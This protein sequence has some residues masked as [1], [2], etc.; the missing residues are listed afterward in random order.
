MRTDGIYRVS[1]NLSQ[2]Q[3]LRFQ[4]D[5][6][7]YSGMESE[8]DVNVLTGLLKLFFRELKE[9]MVPFYLYDRLM[10]ANSKSAIYQSNP[11]IFVPCKSRFFHPKKFRKKKP[12]RRN[13]KNSLH[14]CH[15][16]TPKLYDISCITYIGNVCQS[17]K[18]LV[19]FYLIDFDSRIADFGDQNRMHL[20]NLAI[21]FGPTLMWPEVPSV[22]LATDMVILMKILYKN[23]CF[24]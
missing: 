11:F 16:Q 21:V 23:S 3:K 22:N 6:D 10:K 24:I 15:G 8:E 14:N 5:Q 1:G 13:S 18:A 2:V 4:I 20:P 17:V 9:P 12:K 19:N 7:K